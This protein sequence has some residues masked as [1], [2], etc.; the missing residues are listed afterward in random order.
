M[1]LRG[2]WCST[3]SCSY[4]I[5]FVDVAP[6]FSA[7]CF[8]YIHVLLM[9]LVIRKPTCWLQE[10]VWTWIR[11][12]IRCLWI[13]YMFL[14]CGSRFIFLDTGWITCTFSNNMALKVFVIVLLYVLYKYDFFS[15][16]IT[17]VD[18][19]PCFIDLTLMYMYRHT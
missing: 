2:M 16:D 1:H 19:A 9:S 10:V 12:F 15:Y 8:V 6:C 18:I 5:A 17:F 4:S 11:S 3:S 7:L 13:T 14:G